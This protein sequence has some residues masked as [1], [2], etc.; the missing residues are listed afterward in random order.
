MGSS[1]FTSAGCVRQARPELSKPMSRRAAIWRDAALE[2]RDGVLMGESLAA[3]RLGSQIR[4]IAPYFR[5]ALIRGEAGTG[6]ELVARALHALS[7]G[8]NGPFVVARLS[9]LT[10]S[11]ANRSAPGSS[12]APNAD[13]LL[14]S[15]DG[16]TLYL[17]GV[18]ELSVEL[19]SALLEFLKA[20]EDRRAAPGHSGRSDFG[21]PATGSPVASELGTRILAASDRDLRTLAAIGQFRQDLYALLSAVEIAVPPL[22]QRTEDIPALAQWILRRMAAESRQEPGLLAEATICALQERQWPGNLG[23]LQRVLTQAAALSG[24]GAIEPRHLLALAEP[25]CGHAGARP[26]ARVE[27]LQDVVQQ[28]VL[29]VLTRCGGNKLRAAEALGISRSTLYRMLEAGPATSR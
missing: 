5:T 23:E 2:G 6:K 24:G 21:R 12:H 25:V 10:E 26:A 20:C 17:D 29:N 15:A 18:G 4:R 1:N 14:E 13:S 27:R 22:R 16:G 19:Q 3:R 7:P 9:I 11:F 8:A 28:H